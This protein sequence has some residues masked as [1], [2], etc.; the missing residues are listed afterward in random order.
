MSLQ[1]VSKESP[2]IPLKSG[3]FLNE[4]AISSLQFPWQELPLGGRFQYTT[5]RYTTILTPRVQS[6]FIA[7]TMATPPTY[8]VTVHQGRKLADYILE[9]LSPTDRDEFLLDVA[10][11]ACEA[12]QSFDWWRLA[13][14]L[15]GWEATAEVEESPSLA[16]DLD[17]A[18]KAYRSGN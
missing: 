2:Y 16:V 10:Y 11:S 18:I 14:T 13:E 12:L 17:E 9:K 15:N 6:M 4:V 3:V 1:A 8:R 5:I 7:P